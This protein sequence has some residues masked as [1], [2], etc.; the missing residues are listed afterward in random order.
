LNRVVQ[1]DR[2]NTAQAEGAFTLSSSTSLRNPDPK[3]ELRR[4]LR[5][6]RRALLPDEQR[7]AARAL[8]RHVAATALFRVSRRIACYLAHDG[9]I[10]LSMIIGRAWRM[11]KQPFLPVL[12]P[13]AADRLW[14]AAA[15]P[16]MELRPNR[17]GILE[18]AANAAD[19][20]RADQLDLILMPLVAFDVRGNRLGMGGGFYDKSVEFLRRRRHWKTPR[21]LGIGYD[22]QKVAQLPISDW[23]V[24]LDGV[25]TERAVYMIQ[26]NEKHA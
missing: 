15:T 7:R 26:P 20:V 1:G 2:Y 5:A 3:S 24:P 6:Q 14:F 4:R 11:H 18:P 16:G 19:L 17:F 9:E 21:L 22:F 25:V 12:S 23:D 8:T 13:L 10:D